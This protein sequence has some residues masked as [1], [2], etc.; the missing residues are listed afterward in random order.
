MPLK[1]ASVTST[2]GGTRRSA[3]GCRGISRFGRRRRSLGGWSWRAVIATC[4]GWGG[5]GTAFE[6]GGVPARA[7]ELKTRSRELLGERRFTAGGTLTQRR[8]RHFLQMVF[9][10]A[11]SAAFIGVNWHGIFAEWTLLRAFDCKLF[12]SQ[13]TSAGG[14]YSKYSYTIV[15][16]LAQRVSF[17][18]HSF[19]L[20]WSLCHH[21]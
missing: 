10:E 9:C 7:F 11:A 4:T 3:G 19:L 18:G 8:I 1:V 2:S 21:E 16:S 17:L 6:I 14:T 5:A 20:I 15:S 12:K 13:Q